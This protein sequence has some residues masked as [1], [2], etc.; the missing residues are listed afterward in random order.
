MLIS[1]QGAGHGALGPSACATDAVRNF[2]GD[3]RCPRRA[4]P[5][6]RRP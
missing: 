2:L 4:P 6:H 3:G 1:G 5:A